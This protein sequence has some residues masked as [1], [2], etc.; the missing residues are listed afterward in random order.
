MPTSFR[1]IRR[2]DPDVIYGQKYSLKSLRNI[3][4]AGEHC[5]IETKNWIERVF[6]VPVLNHWWQTESGSPV[7]ATCTGFK[8]SLNPPKYT[9][10]LPYLGYNSK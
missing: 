2:V 9:T 3:F 6:K 8:H 10:G 1:V 7:T 4:I 5:D